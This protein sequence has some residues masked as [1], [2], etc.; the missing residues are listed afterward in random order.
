MKNLTFLFVLCRWLIPGRKII[1]TT[2]SFLGLL[3]LNSLFN[4]VR[5]NILSLE[6]DAKRLLK[7]SEILSKKAQ[8]FNE[9]KVLM[10]LGMNSINGFYYRFD[11]QIKEALCENKNFDKDKIQKDVDSFS[12]EFNSYEVLQFKPKKGK[13]ILEGGVLKLKYTEGDYLQNSADLDIVKDRLAE[14]ELRIKLGK[15]ERIKLSWGMDSTVEWKKWITIDTIPDNTFH[16]YKINIKNVLKAFHKLDYQVSVSGDIIKK[17]FLIPSNIH[18]DQVEID[19][20]RFISKREK[21]QKE[22]YSETYE[23]VN[24]EMRKVI[25]TTTPLCLRYPVNIPEGKAFLRFGMGILEGDDPVIFR[26]VVKCDNNEQEVFFKEV[27][28]TDEWQDARIDFSDWS[29]R[30]VE[31]LFETESA[32]GN[33]AFWSNPILYIPPKERFSVIILLEDALRPDHMS[34][35]GYCRKTTPIKDIFIKRGVLFFNAFS[36]ATKTRP[37]CPSIMT[38]LYPTATGVWNFS[39]M[40]SDRYLTL[41][42]IMRNQGF[43]TA[44]FIQNTSAGPYAGLHQGFSNLFDAATMGD[45]AEEIYG[46]KLYE[47]IEAHSDRNFFLYL[48]LID[49]HGPYDPPQPFDSHYQDAPLGKTVVEKSVFYDPEWVKTPAL[50]GRRLLYDGEVQYNDFYFGRFLEKLKEY[51]LLNNTLIVFIADH[52]EHL[53]E[54]G[55][56]GHDPPGYIQGIHVPLLMVYPEELPMNVKI[57]KPVQLIDIMPTVLDLASIDK[58]DLLIEG[59]SLVSLMHGKKLNFWNNRLSISEEVVHKDKN[60]KSEWASIFYKNWHIIN[61]NRLSDS[62]SKLTKYFNK[63][64]H[65]ILFGTRVFNYFKDKEEEHFLNSFLVDMFFRYKVKHFVRKLQENNMTIWKALTKDTEKTIK[66]D[67]EERERLRALGYL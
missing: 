10:K 11:E 7:K 35:Y 52:G 5:I 28:S 51:R 39:E 19:Y 49:P 50:E 4:A 25:Y 27:M 54:H 46:K 47:W 18:N 63:K 2:L 60:D 41:A 31:I 65:G 33:I 6:N 40:L 53:G 34:C 22:L 43:A 12:F 16:I 20:I 38:S 59:D 55:L 45:R 62:L 17:V 26:V 3:I 36:Q 57:I 13:F 14:I 64:N 29:G 8:T 66:Y 30:S 1:I 23:T 15:G 48:H 42:E 21:Y 44:A 24:K 37:S 58:G 9:K 32:K 67:P 61:S 56:W